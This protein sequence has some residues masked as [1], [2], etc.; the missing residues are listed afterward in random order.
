MVEDGKA[1]AMSRQSKL[2]F[3]HKVFLDY[4][5][6]TSVCEKKEED[7]IFLKQGGMTVTQ[8]D[9]NFYRLARFGPS[10]VMNDRNRGKKFV[11]GLN[12]TLQIDLSAWNF[13]TYS[14]ALD[15]SIENVTST[16]TTKSIL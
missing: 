12:L 11:N 15:K 13:E 16:E 7:F 5:F 14:K 1:K 10:L 9:K 3:F 8:Y 6:S 2:N 4:Y